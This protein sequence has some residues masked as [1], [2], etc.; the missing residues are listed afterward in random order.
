MCLEGK[1]RDHRVDMMDC[2][3]MFKPRRYLAICVWVVLGGWSVQGRTQSTTDSADIEELEEVFCPPL[4]HEHWDRIV[5]TYVTEDGW[6]D[7]ERLN[8][9]TPMHQG[10]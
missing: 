3:H 1:E 9:K 4:N 6:F 2:A 7:Y 8:S 5:S 10:K